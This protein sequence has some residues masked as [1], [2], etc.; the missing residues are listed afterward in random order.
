MAAMNQQQE[1]IVRGWAAAN[2]LNPDI[3]V[4]EANNLLQSGAYPTFDALAETA[5]IK[6]TDELRQAPV[7]TQQATAFTAQPIDN[8]MT[9][10]RGWFSQNPNANQAQ[11]QSAMD[12]YGVSPT[13]V[14]KAMGNTRLPN[15]PAS[16]QVA[17]YQNITGNRSDIN[18]INRAIVARN[19]GV[20]AEELSGLGGMDAT[21]ALSLT[22]RMA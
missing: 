15:A 12:Q 8:Q 7:A 18:D 11:I 10:I 21:Q 6:R 3:Q 14:A 22:G 13:T 2:G 1:K 20:S 9:Q 16:I 4:N 5:S 17:Q 19:L